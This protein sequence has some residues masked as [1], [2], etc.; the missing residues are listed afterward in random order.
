[1]SNSS[2]VIDLQQPRR[3]TKLFNNNSKY[4]GDGDIYQSVNISPT[5]RD[6]TKLEDPLSQLNLSEGKI[7]L[8][9]ICAF[10]YSPF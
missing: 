3:D 9:V 4:Y 7:F 2:P 8:L 6:V 10:F 5:K 1:M